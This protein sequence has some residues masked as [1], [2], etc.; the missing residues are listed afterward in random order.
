[1]INN[2]NDEKITFEK[3]PQAVEYLINKVEALAEA[4][5]L[6]KD[7]NKPEEKDR[8]LNMDELIKYLPDHP[9]KP[10]IYGWVSNRQIPH[11]KGGK[12]LRFLKSEIDKWLST[13]RRKT[14]EEIMAEAQN[15]ASRKKGGKL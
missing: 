5:K 15:Y 9:A 13:G 11:H 1:M 14:N 7:E 6:K 4:L 3:L 10:T 8:W 2:M 12:K